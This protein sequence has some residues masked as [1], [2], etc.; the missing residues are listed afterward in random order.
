[1]VSVRALSST[2]LLKYPEAPHCLACCLYSAESNAVRKIIGI[3]TSLSW[4]FLQIEIPSKPFI[5]KSVTMH[6]ISFRG[7]KSRSIGSINAVFP[8][9]KKYQPSLKT[10]KSFE[11]TLDRASSTASNSSGHV[12]PPDLIC[13]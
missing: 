9:I 6:D 11:N 5:F 1:M 3:F 10:R 7:L 8:K 13:F 2:G 4:R 12:T